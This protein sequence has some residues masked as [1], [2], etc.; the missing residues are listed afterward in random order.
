MADKSNQQQLPPTPQYQ[1]DPQFRQALSDLTS[2]GTRL[3]NLDFSGGWNPL[4]Q[5]TTQFNPATLQ[6]YIDTLTKQMT[7]AFRDSNQA[8]I[9]QLAA[10]GSLDSSTTAN[11][12]GKNYSDF[13]NT[14]AVNAG[15][16]GLAQVEQALQNR[17]TLEGTGLNTLNSAAGMG[18]GNEQALNQFNLSN[19]DNQVA[20]QMYQDQ[21]QA[22]GWLGALKGGVGGGLVGAGLSVAAAPFTGGASLAFLPTALGAGVLAG[23]ALGA[24]SPQSTSNSILSGGLASGSSA[25]SYRPAATASN[26]PFRSNVGLTDLT[27]QSSIDLASKYPML[28]GNGAS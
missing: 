9:N 10:S 16:A 23:G 6:S 27:N 5:E 18:Q 21:N 17:V 2:T 28:F 7:P 25:L 24:L 15:S 14:L 1:Q 26:N 12:L 19:Y 4:L 22:G 11:M 3:S 13:Q 8:L 20:A